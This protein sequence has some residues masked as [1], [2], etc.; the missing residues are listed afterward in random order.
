MY[1]NKDTKYNQAVA[2]YG[3][4]SNTKDCE[5]MNTALSTLESSLEF[6]NKNTKAMT[7]HKAIKTFISN[8]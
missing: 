4:A 2:L 7:L 5:L 8:H 1:S 6:Q 3:Q